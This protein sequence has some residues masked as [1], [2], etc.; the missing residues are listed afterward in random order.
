MEGMQDAYVKA[1]VPQ[2]HRRALNKGTVADK[3]KEIGDYTMKNL[4][5]DSVCLASTLREAPPHSSSVTR[6]T[7]PIS[8]STF[9]AALR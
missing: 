7:I 6:K 1:E 8:S 5:R 4:G 3:E 9:R 2:E